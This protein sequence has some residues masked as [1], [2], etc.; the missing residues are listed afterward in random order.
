MF[1]VIDVSAIVIIEL[2]NIFFVSAK[3]FFKSSTL[4]GM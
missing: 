3:L 1:D 4:F 2:P